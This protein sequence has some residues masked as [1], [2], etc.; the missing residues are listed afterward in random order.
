MHDQYRPAGV[1]EMDTPI[2]SP[3][4]PRPAV[5][6]DLNGL[7]G[8]AIAL[9]VVF[10]VWMGRVSGGVDVFLTL[11]GFFFTAS[12]IRAAASGGSLNPFARLGRVLRRLG[13]PLAIVLFA[14]AVA[15]V[16]ILPRTRWV[17]IGNQLISGVFF[18][19]NWELA[20]TSQDYLAADPDVSPL[21]HLWSVA[22][23][24]QFY[25]VVTLVVFGLAWVLRRSRGGHRHSPHPSLFLVVFL[26]SAVISFVYA[27]D[28]ASRLQAWNYYDTGARLW[29]ILLGAAVAA[30]FAWRPP[31]STSAAQS[32]PARW[33]RTCLAGAGLLF[34]MACG[35]I[36]DGVQEFPGPWALLPVLATIALVVAGPNTPIARL[37][38][39]RFGLWLGSIA[40][41]L[42]LWHWP[43]LIF[44]LAYTGDSKATLA[45]GTLIVVGSV[46]LAVA[47]VRLVEKPVQ[48]SP[49]SITARGITATALAMSAVM[50]VGAV[51]WD[52]H[53]RQSVTDVQAGR[54]LDPSTHPGAL[55]LT[56]GVAAD[57]AEILP[58]LFSAP[59]DVPLTTMEGC[60]TA[61]ESSVPLTCEYGDVRAE[62]T[63]V[64]AG[65]SHAEHWLTALD[66]LG[67]ERG[68]RVVTFVKVGCPITAGHMVLL[69]ENEYPDCVEWS[70][71]ALNQI[72]ELRPDYVFTTSSRPR[73][74]AP[75]D[76]T[77][78][79]Y[80]DVWNEL[81]SYGISVLA[82]RDNPWLF[83]DGMPYRAVDCLADGGSATSCGVLRNDA[84]D[85][86]NPTLAA[87]FR[88]SSVF[89]LD[90]T[91]ALCDSLVCRVVEGN[92]V[93]YRDE[94]H[95]TATYMRTMSAELA[96]QM[97]AATG[98]W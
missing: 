88:L 94:H 79:W 87:S 45:S 42:Y 67:L 43:L 52:H 61:I 57:D 14:V 93:I 13:P 1:S 3:R 55:A 20:S 39:T 29:E 28:G 84:L 81:A 40:F 24:F 60:I 90:L 59:E 75:G 37:L 78:D 19:V 17:D 69:G 27:A 10:H 15:T 48:M 33:A 82:V 83:R 8:V 23:Q 63:I 51:A 86:V 73:E 64:L 11:T 46:A 47:T 68:F 97:S 74:D 6:Q 18:F 80:I 72:E 25:L 16:V 62:R 49:R 38:A 56:R 21:Q 53:V 89:P 5:R 95:L 36:V 92:V 66:L 96:Q 44:V 50:V 58:D 26:G 98:W 54:A 4:A 91:N 71:T 34:I 30:L 9:V 2:G 77:P 12:L 32:W 76:Y 35:F 41:P 7:R 22:V 85:S 65:G 70:R 31:A